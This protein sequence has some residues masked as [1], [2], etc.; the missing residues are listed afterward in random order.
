MWLL[1]GV[2]ASTPCQGDASTFNAGHGG[3]DSYAS[4]GPDGSSNYIPQDG[5][6]FCV[7]TSWC[8]HMGL[9]GGAGGESGCLSVGDLICTWFAPAGPAPCCF[10]PPVVHPGE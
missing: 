6:E 8:I 2:Y 10:V 4:D 7:Q 9:F 5:D 1:L 3:C